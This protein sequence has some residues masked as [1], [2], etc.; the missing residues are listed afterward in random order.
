MS[1][2]LVNLNAVTPK[3]LTKEGKEELMRR[4]GYLYKLTVLHGMDINDLTFKTTEELKALLGSKAKAHKK[5]IEEKDRDRIF[6]YQV[7]K[8]SGN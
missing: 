2:T 1:K 3:N 7:R 6:E 8:L 5:S 4:E